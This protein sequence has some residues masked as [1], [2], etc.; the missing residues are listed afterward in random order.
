MFR[1]AG[2]E[3]GLSQL[4]IDIILYITNNPEFN[5]ARDLCAR[6]GIAKSNA[7]T[8]IRS[9]EQKQLI[10]ITIDSKIRKIHRLDLSEKG[11]RIAVVLQ[12]IQKKCFETMLSG[13]S[14]DEIRSMKNFLERS[15]RN[16]SDAI[17]EM[18]GRK[19]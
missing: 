10:E 13:F 1:E 17:K 4:E 8:G 9:L 7:S 12:E 15:D 14:E 19:C 3:Y 2:K 6:R 5:T 18:E 16:I 11:K